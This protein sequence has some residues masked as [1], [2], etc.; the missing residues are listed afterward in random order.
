MKSLRTTVTSN[1]LFSNRQNFYLQNN[2]PPQLKRKSRAFIWEGRGKA[3]VGAVSVP[4]SLDCAT[5]KAA[6]FKRRS[7]TTLLQ[8]TQLLAINAGHLRADELVNADATHLR[9][10]NRSY[11]TRFRSIINFLTFGIVGGRTR[12][13]KPPLIHS[14]F[15]LSRKVTDLCETNNARMTITFN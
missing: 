12:K 10:P 3:P 5:E 11:R 14:P 9:I 2:S 8:T 6:P 13:Q 1:A 7:I 4:A 15:W